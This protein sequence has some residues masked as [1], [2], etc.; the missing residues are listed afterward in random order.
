MAAHY[1]GVFRQRG[2]D[3]VFDNDNKKRRAGFADR[4]IASGGRELVSHVYSRGRAAHKARDC[5][6]GAVLVRRDMERLFRTVGVSYRPLAQNRSGRY[7][8]AQRHRV[9]SVDRHAV[10]NGGGVHVVAARYSAVHNNEQSV[11]ADQR[12]VGHKGVIYV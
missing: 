9:A 11:C 3:A 1:S 12:H 2:N 8:D 6:A 10:F 5:G 7:H 4:G